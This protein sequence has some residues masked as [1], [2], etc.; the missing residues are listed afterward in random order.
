MQEY[1]SIFC[2]CIVLKPLSIS[3]NC[4][5]ILFSEFYFQARDVMCHISEPF[6]CKTFIQRK[7]RDW[8]KYS[9]SFKNL[10]TFGVL[11]WNK[12]YI[13]FVVT[14]KVLR[15]IYCIRFWRP[16]TILDGVSRDPGTFHSEAKNVSVKTLSILMS[17][18]SWCFVWLSKTT[19]PVSK[20]SV[21]VLLFKVKFGT[22]Y[23]KLTRLCG[24]LFIDC[25][26]AKHV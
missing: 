20:L 10:L 1:A 22:M 2:S 23:E 17:V 3:E 15:W 8:V 5:E 26:R 9:F 6:F 12:Q 24:D 7:Q 11:R 25:T 13:C 14:F 4:T 19:E 21:I 18:F 16:V